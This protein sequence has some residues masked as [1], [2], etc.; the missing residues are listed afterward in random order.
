[1]AIIVMINAISQNSV[2]EKSIGMTV[3]IDETIAFIERQITQVD[4]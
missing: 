4:G 1:M 2:L 3:G